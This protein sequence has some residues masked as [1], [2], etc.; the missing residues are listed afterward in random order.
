VRTASVAVLLLGS[1]LVALTASDGA[2]SASGRQHQLTITV[3]PL[4]STQVG[5]KHLIESDQATKDGK[6]VGYTANSCTFDFAAGVA[7]CLVTLARPQGQLRAKVTV[8]AQ[9]NVAEGRI[10]GG[11]GAYRGASGTVSGGPGPKS[12]TQVITLTWQN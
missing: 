12:G 5:E 4:D 2:A 8:D 9:N 6:T 1:G 3:H 7:H 10:V 11:T